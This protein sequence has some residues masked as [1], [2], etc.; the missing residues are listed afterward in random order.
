MTVEDSTTDS[1]PF[2]ANALSTAVPLPAG[3][4]VFFLSPTH[5]CTT[6]PVGVHLHWQSSHWQPAAA[7]DRWIHG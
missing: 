1:R 3:I 4:F 5:K 2:T 7:M 6:V